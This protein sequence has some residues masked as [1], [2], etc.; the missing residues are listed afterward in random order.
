MPPDVT[1]EVES[2]SRVG[3]LTPGGPEVMGRRHEL[4]VMGSGRGTYDL[5]CPIRNP[6][7]SPVTWSQRVVLYRGTVARAPCETT[8]AGDEWSG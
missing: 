5:A 2:R 6:L 1:L 7:T 4:E 8:V 3:N